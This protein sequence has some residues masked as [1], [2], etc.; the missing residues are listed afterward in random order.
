MFLLVQISLTQPIRSQFSCV[1]KKKN[2]A[3]KLQREKILQ[4]RAAVLEKSETMIET[5]V[6]LLH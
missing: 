1:K 4:M 2:S 3:V 6:C 5:I